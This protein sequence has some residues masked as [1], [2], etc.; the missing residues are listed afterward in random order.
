M[1]ISCIILIPVSQIV[2]MCLRRY[3][4]TIPSH[5]SV[6]LITS[7]SHACRVR[8]LN[9]SLELL[10]AMSCKNVLL[11]L[12]SL[13]RGGAHPSPPEKR[14]R[15]NSQS[16][17]WSHRTGSWDNGRQLSARLGWSPLASRFSGNGKEIL[18][19]GA[20]TRERSRVESLFF[21]LATRFRV[22]CGVSLIVPPPLICRPIRKSQIYSPTCQ[23]LLSRNCVISIFPRRARSGTSAFT[24]RRPAQIVS[25]G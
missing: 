7:P 24:R 25:R 10:C 20:Q 12:L 17:S 5:I 8:P 16:S 3:A 22:R 6:V 13:A 9:R 18:R 1:K 19:N 14:L 11:Q 4:L 23:R 2:L 21:V 15:V